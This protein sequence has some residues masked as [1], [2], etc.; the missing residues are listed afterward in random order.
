MDLSKKNILITGASS[1]IGEALATKLAKEAAVLI[2]VARRL[3]QM[4][5][6]KTNLIKE[7]SQLIVKLFPK[8]ITIRENQIYILE[9]LK[10]QEIDIDVL[11]NNAGTG[12]ENLFHNSEWG[13]AEQIIDLNVKSVI[14][15]THLIVPQFLKQP[16]SKCIVFIGS[17]GG[18]AWMPG[19]LVYSA[20]KHF[21]TAAAIILKAELK[22][23]GVQVNL[24]CP[25]PVDTGFDTASDTI[26]G[27]KGG[28][29]QGT[30]ISAGQCADDIIKGVKKNQAVIFP[31]KKFNLLMQ[32]YLLLPWVIRR[33]MLEKDAKKFYS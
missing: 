20:T 19:S 6:L 22:S 29:A 11:I 32:F 7:N 5:E 30:R 31:G 10:E 12:D 28:P 27:M 23:K 15:F 3:E 8:D 14:S 1:G 26:G 21:I 17:G 33:K 2:L 18:I 16:Q 24:V 4:E 13:K 9:S 25:G